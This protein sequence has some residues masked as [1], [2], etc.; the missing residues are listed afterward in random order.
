MKVIL[1]K[2]VAKVGRR[3]EVREVA[4]GYAKNF[5][6]ARGL[7]LPATVENIRKLNH[8]QSLNMALL[9]KQEAELER[10]LAKLARQKII[11]SAKADPVSGQL[12]AG[13][14]QTDITAALAKQTGGEIRFEATSL[15]LP[16]VIRKV[17][18]YRINVKSGQVAGQ[19]TLLVEPEIKKR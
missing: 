19:F 7:A 13:I 16:E 14:R 1:L 2:D 11:I 18:E 4:D 8:E 17:G 6:I 12:F 3:Q 5:L 9:A 10:F 15:V